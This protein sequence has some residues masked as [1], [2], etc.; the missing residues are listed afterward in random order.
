VALLT[1]AEVRTPASLATILLQ[2]ASFA[3]LGLLG[4]AIVRARPET[5]PEESA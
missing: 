5:D 2:A 3:W 4:V 1:F